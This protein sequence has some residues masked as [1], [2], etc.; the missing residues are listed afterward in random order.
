MLRK[1]FFVYYLN[2]FVKQFYCYLFSISRSDK[3]GIEAKFSLDNNDE[4]KKR[5][6]GPMSIDRTLKK[7]KKRLPEKRLEN[8]FNHC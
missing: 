8:S 2:D 4:R 7:W 6:L 3:S 1:I 5:R